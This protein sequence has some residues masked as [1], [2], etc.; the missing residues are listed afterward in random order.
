MIR[1]RVM[2]EVLE[3]FRVATLE[4]VD[5]LLCRKCLGIVKL[6]YVD[7]FRVR[8][9]RRSCKRRFSALE[10][11]M[12]SNLHISWTKVLRIVLYLFNEKETG[13]ISDELEVDGNTGCVPYIF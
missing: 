13:E 5:L 9:R 10:D 7:T 1:K 6:I 2:D 8:C 12:I 4:H 11:T 3:E